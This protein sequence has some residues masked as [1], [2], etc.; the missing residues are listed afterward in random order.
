[1]TTDMNHSMMKLFIVITERGLAK[2]VD[3]FLEKLKIPIRYQILCKG[4]ADSEFLQICGLEGTTRV[5]TAGLIRASMAYPVFYGMETYLKLKEK[6]RGIAF[7]VP[8]N[9]AQTYLV[10]QMNGE[11]KNAME[12]IQDEREKSMKENMDYAMILTTCRQGFSENVMEAARRA[13]AAGGTVIKGRREGIG[14]PMRFMGISTQEEREL[15][16]ILVP[17]EIKRNTM[18]EISR[19]CGIQTE[20]GGMVLSMPVDEMIGMADD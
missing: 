3:D 1:M 15:V 9:G 12:K 5:M 17:K 18:E 13:G 11:Q 2:K 16:I 20:A 4:T 7:T 14:G 6:G 19:S 8:V 10:N